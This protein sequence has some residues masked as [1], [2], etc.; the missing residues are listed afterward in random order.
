MNESKEWAR[1]MERAI[2]AAEREIREQN[3][4]F[5]EGLEAWGS[6]EDVARFSAVTRF[7]PEPARKRTPMRGA[8]LRG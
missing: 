6:D 5:A 1:S 3:A 2:V 7:S 8:L 4:Q